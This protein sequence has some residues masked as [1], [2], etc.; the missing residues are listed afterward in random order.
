[1]EEYAVIAARAGRREVF[2][3]G[4]YPFPSL[5]ET[6]R[7]GQGNG[8]HEKHTSRLSRN[9]GGGLYGNWMGF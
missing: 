1:M 3:R 7:A 8:Q 6:G 5:P 9:T 2:L 4:W